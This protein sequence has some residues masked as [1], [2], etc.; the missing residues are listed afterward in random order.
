MTQFSA[1]FQ[2]GKIGTL[3]LKNRIIMPAMGT[4]LA[5][6][7]GKVTD[8]MVAYYAARARGGAGL[9]TP[10]FAAV[11]RDSAFA[12]TLPLH[13]DSYIADWRTLADAVHEAGA[14]FSIQ[15]MHVGL[16][17]LYSG[18]VPEGAS[19]LVPS[20]APWMAP[21]KPY[22]E[23][24]EQ[25][26]LGCVEDFA[27]AAARAKIAGADLVE[28][29]ACHGCLVSSF[30]SPLTNRRQDRFGGNVEN[31]TR[32]ACL[33]VEAIRRAVGKGFPLSVRINC[34]DGIEGGLTVEEAAQQAR[35]LEGAGAD[36]I[37]VSGGLE[38]WST[39]S[40]PSYPYP[41][42]PM[43]GM[44]EKIKKAVNVPVIVAGKVNAELAEKVISGGKADFVAMGRPLLADPELPNKIRQGRIDDLRRCIYCN[45]C[46]KSATDPSA[47][48]MSCTVN[49]FVAREAKYPFKPVAK[50]KEVMVAGGGLAGMEMAMYLTERG[51]KVALYEK[52]NELGGQW[53]IAC[54]LPGKQGYA[55]L[56]EYLK[57][58]LKKNG[59]EI[60]L[61][62][63]VTRELVLQKKPD[64][65]VVATGAVPLR[66]NVPGADLPHVIQGHDF[67]AGR[68]PARGRIVVVGGRFIGME[69]AIWL[70]EQGKDVT[71]VTRAGLGED[72]IRLEEFTFK[73]LADRIVELNIP[74]FLNS[75]VLEITE[76]AVVIPMKG[77]LFRIPADTVI[78]SVGM[79][80]E[81][82][83]A[84]ELEGL[85][86]EVHMVGD[87][88][89]PRDAS[90]V[91][92]QAARLAATI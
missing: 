4:A 92:Y 9:I 29:H 11:S 61:G 2:P 19:I 72:G 16:I 60:N 63:A 7:K 22:H 14:R 62:T 5:D 66:L 26:I 89:R 86:I 48:P 57:R 39:L 20:M 6:E 73:T 27:A 15:L 28:L 44:A 32:F 35:I 3:Q 87:C 58:W 49:P 1:L 31:R 23:L 13:D 21:D 91:S 41:D 75:T 53:N 55:A 45:N 85:G 90:D 10:Q 40:V 70:K 69:V 81:N 38:F 37:S 59:V 36:A 34:S 68:A 46:L 12:Y 51:H 83:L 77:R 80:P 65:V 79:R 82:R 33:I 78:L 52:D 54:A 64:A 56:T 8:R 67:I 84:K 30:L 50:P 47:G 24:T 74:M 71:I 18:V 43:V 17:L 42:G 76:K 25:D 88:V